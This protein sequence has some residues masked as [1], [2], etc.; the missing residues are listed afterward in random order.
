MY[1]YIHSIFCCICVSLLSKLHW[2]AVLTLW[3]LNSG[4]ILIIIWELFFGS[5]LNYYLGLKCNN[6]LQVS[7]LSP[8][9]FVSIFIYAS[10]LGLLDF[11]NLT[12]PLFTHKMLLISRINTMI[13]DIDLVYF[14]SLIVL[15]NV[16]RWQC[17]WL[18]YFL[19]GFTDDTPRDYHCNLG[20]DGRRRDADERPELCRGTVE[21]VASKEYMV[22]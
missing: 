9:G 12:F 4:L 20:P 16:V 22:C 11:I 6:N 3:E 18:F 8:I 14:C 21:F 5:C 10:N 7:L 15:C 2:L 13:I 17:H 1:A 19:S